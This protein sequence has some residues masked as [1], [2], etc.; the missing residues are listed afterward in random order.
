VG[1]YASQIF[2]IPALLLYREEIHKTP[3]ERAF[4]SNRDAAEDRCVGLLEEFYGRYPLEAAY[5]NSGENFLFPFLPP[6]RCNSITLPSQYLAPGKLEIYF[7]LSPTVD[8][9]KWIGTLLTRFWHY[10]FTS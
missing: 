4:H 9:R 2:A 5:S 1:S 8:S 10:I 6:L 3:M 7:P